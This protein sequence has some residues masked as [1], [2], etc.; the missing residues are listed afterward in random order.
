MPPGTHARCVVGIAHV[1]PAR[2]RPS[3][4]RSHAPDAAGPALRANDA[5]FETRPRASRSAPPS[6]AP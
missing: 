6:A 3:A 1:H 5:T 2:G 4:L